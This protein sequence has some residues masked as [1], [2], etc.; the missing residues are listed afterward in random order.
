MAMDLPVVASADG[1]YPELVGEA[2]LLVP[3]GDPAALAEA[4]E[5]MITS[6]RLR[7]RHAARARPQAARH[8]WDATAGALGALA[9]R[10][11]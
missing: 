5:R 8:T 11:L 7:A 4:L 3:P 10:L 2:A 9:E 6:P 1:G